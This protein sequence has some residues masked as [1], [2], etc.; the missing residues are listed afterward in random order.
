[1]SSENSDPFRLV[2]GGNVAL[3]SLGADLGGLTVSLDTRGRDG[4]PVDADISVLLLDEGGRVRSSADLVFY[5]QPIGLGGAV[6]LRDKVQPEP[7][8]SEAGEGWS[9]DVI[10]LELDDVSEEVERIVVG[11]DR[12]GLGSDIR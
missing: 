1:M 11:R 6:H 2:K 12:P 7:G 5:N 9:S 8:S 4:S 3:A 10:T